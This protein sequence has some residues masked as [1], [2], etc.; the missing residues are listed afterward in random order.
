MNH[1]GYT[2]RDFDRNPLVFYYEA[3]LDAFQQAKQA[4]VRALGI[5]LDGADAVTRDPLE[6]EPD[7]V[8]AS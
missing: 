1:S 2:E 8:L 4:G 3:T 5:S 6:S 7:C